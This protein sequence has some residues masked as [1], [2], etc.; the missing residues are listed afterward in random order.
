[1]ALSGSF[2]GAASSSRPGS[3]Y[4]L[5]VDWSAKQN[6][7]NNTSTITCDFYLE[8]DATWSIGIGNRNNTCTIDGVAVAWTSPTV[9]NGGG[10]TTKIGSCS[11]TVSHNSDGTKS[12]TISAVYK[13]APLTISGTDIN[14]ISASATITLD[15][16]ARATQ[17]TLSVSS[18]ELGSAITIGLESASS[19]FTH[20]LRYSIGNASGEISSNPWTIPMDLAK[21]IPD[22]PDGTLTIYCDT[23]SNGTLIG[24][25][26][27]SVKAMVPES[28]K[29]DVELRGCIDDSGAYNLLGTYVQNVSRLELYA[30]TNGIYGSWITGLSISLD[31]KPYAS[32]DLVTG[33]GDLKLLLIATDS[34]GRSNTVEETISVAAYKEPKLNLDA[35]RCEANGTANDA[36]E[37]A[38][39]TVSGS[40]EQVNNRNK[41]KCMLTYG[42]TTVD[43]G[44]GVGSFSKELIVAVSSQSTMAISA[45]LSDMLKILPR[46]M[47]LSTGY[48]TMDFLAGGKGIAFGTTATK[49]GFTC[50]MDTDFC[51]HKVTGL[52]APVNASDAVS[53][54]YVDNLIASIQTALNNLT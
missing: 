38:K 54:E 17:P 51:G 10:T 34:R 15:T 50:S 39:I 4:R 36:G 1:M 49:E 42:G 27:V 12:L 29:P 14:S 19:S 35:H 31:G 22:S 21:Q 20:G 48:A 53:K 6:V 30:P 43:L 24:T 33:S 41:A 18:V 52:P 8:Q 11:R 7:A 28:I 9:S 44:V 37:Y 5:R 23:Y 3:A 47:V 32:G 2:V 40:T 13:T 26:P 45:T 16:I 25:K 46:S